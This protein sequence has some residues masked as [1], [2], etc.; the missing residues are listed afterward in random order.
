MTD[1]MVSIRLPESLFLELKRLAEKEHYM[2]I[3]EQIRSIVRDKWLYYKQPELMELKKL[4]EG[5]KKELK[6]K[7]EKMLRLEIIKELEKIKEE[8]RKEGLLK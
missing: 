8:I 7:S 1:V 2:D 5:I 4:R 3:S 6:K